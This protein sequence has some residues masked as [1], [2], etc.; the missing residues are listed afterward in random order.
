MIYFLYVYSTKS[1]YKLI[2]KKSHVRDYMTKKNIKFK[3]KQNEKV[4]CFTNG[5]FR[6]W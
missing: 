4:K 1:K 5:K 6:R 2:S 3:I